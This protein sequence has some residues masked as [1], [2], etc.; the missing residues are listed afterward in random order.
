[1]YIEKQSGVVLFPLHEARVFSA[2]FHAGPWRIALLNPKPK[3]T[4]AMTNLPSLPIY[5]HYCM[6]IYI[7]TNMYVY[8]Q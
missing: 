5:V 8:T 2:P 4:K 1:M 7:H 3:H 6:R